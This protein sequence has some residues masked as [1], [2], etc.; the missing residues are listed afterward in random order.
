MDGLILSSI[1]YDDKKEAISQ[2]SNLHCTGGFFC[3][4]V[5][6]LKDEL[7]NLLSKETHSE[8]EQVRISQISK[9]LI[10]INDQQTKGVMTRSKARWTELG[11]KSSKYF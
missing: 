10:E 8:E 6:D 2:K 9:D 11:E 1:T 5:N 3:C 7:T 4:Q